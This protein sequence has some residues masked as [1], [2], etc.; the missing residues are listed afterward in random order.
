[1]RTGQWGKLVIENPPFFFAFLPEPE[2]NPKLTIGT[3]WATELG[4]S[5]Y[6]LLLLFFYSV[7]LKDK[8]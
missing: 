3:S 7:I 8:S 5:F 1:M 4:D 2:K 6:L